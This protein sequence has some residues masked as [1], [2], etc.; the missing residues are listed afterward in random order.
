MYNCIKC[1]KLLKNKSAKVSHENNCDGI[2][3]KSDKKKNKKLD[4]ICPKCGFDIKTSY[5][6][7]YNSCDGK[8]PRRKRIK[9]GHHAWNKNIKYK[10]IFSI[11]KNKEISDKISNKVKLAYKSGRLT[12]KCYNPDKEIERKKKISETM[13]LRRIGGYRK[14]SGRGKQGW[15][16]NYWCDSSWELAYVIYNLEHNIKIERNKE[17]F[18]Y[19]FNDRLYKYMPDFI[20]NGNFIEVKGYITEQVKAKINQFPK[21][22]IVIDKKDIIPYLEYVIS[23]YGKDFVNLYNK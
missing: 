4:K 18:E 9:N 23:K 6:K 17:R 14:G 15:Y 2:G 5:D 3:T 21:K 7:H 12:G 1:N 11:E 13:I 19:I 22:L 8:G 20:V 16:K 10:D